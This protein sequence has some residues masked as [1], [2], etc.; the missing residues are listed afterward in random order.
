MSGSPPNPS[1][2]PERNEP[3]NPTRPVV[4]RKGS[5]SGAYLAIA[6]VVVV[7]V[8]VAVGLST[9]WFGLQKAKSSATCSTGITVQ[10]EGA[11]YFSALMSSWQASF[12]SATSNIVNYQSLGAGAGITA[13]QQKLVDFAATDEPL[14]ASEIAGMPGQTLTLP[15]TGGPLAIIYNIPGYAHP[16]NLSGPLLAAIYNGTITTWNDPALLADNPYLPSGPIYT[17]HRS[18]AA[19]TTFVLTSLLS[20]DSAWWSAHVGTSIQPT[21]PAIAGA[22]AEKGNSA[23]AKY[24]AA[25][26]DTI[27]YV[28]LADAIGAKASYAAVLNPAGHF[29]TPT[30][31]NTQAAIANLSGQP[32]PSATGDWS[33]VSW[34]NSPGSYDYP[35]ALLTYFIVLENPALGYTSSLSHAEALTQWLNWAVTSGQ[36]YS[37]GLYYDNPPATL[38]AQDQAAIGQMTWNGASIPT[39]SS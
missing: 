14:N 27:G 32:L 12:N 26:S 30:V 21:W 3:A 20:D 22:T 17:V 4:R 25:T 31:A 34:V 2:V 10:G 35:L 23:L 9:S 8:V 38:I 29:I 28:D 33:G 18:D 36:S 19:G 7:V 39:C 13:L 24:V 6:V 1:A 37:A 16:L 5:R 11:S 15:V